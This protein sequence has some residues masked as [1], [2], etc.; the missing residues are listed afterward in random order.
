M[1]IRATSSRQFRHLVLWLTLAVSL[2]PRPTPAAAADSVTVRLTEVGPQGLQGLLP[3][4]WSPLLAVHIDIDPPGVTFRIPATLHFLLPERLRVLAPANAEVPAAFYDTTLHA[5]VFHGLARVTPDGTA[6]EVPIVRAGQYA[7]VMPD[8]SPSPLEAG[9][10]VVGA[11]LPGVQPGTITPEATATIEVTPPFLLAGATK[12][13]TARIVV[14]APGPIPSGT[15]VI[16]QIRESFTKRSGEIVTPESYRQDI[17]LYQNPQPGQVGSTSDQVRSAAG[18]VTRLSASFPVKP[19]VRLTPQ[20]LRIGNVNIELLTAVAAPAGTIVGAQGAV[21][22]GADGRT[23]TIPA[24]A[25]T[26][27][28]VASLAPVRPAELTVQIPPGFSLLDAV[29]FELLN[30]LSKSAEL[31]VPLAALSTPLTPGAPLFVARLIPV[32]GLQ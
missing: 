12:P 20:E 6:V 19:S 30:A 10:L 24:N 29:R 22:R 21:V 14:T 25:L 15:R 17:I 27:D 23:L 2:L 11:P 1:G 5:W 16:A 9:P 18:T 28:T 8:A 31:A 7:I 4:G 3:L 32:R 26:R 13:A